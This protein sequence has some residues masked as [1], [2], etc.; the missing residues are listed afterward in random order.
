MSKFA[1]LLQFLLAL[2]GCSMGGTTWTSQVE[3]KGTTLHSKVRLEDGVAQ[4]HCLDSSSGQCHYTLF[5]EACGNQGDCQLAPLQRFSVLRG[6]SRQVAGL[7]GFKPCVA[8]D[9]AP[10]GADCQPVAAQPAAAVNRSAAPAAP[11]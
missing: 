6:E 7:A 10:M 1:A 5:P 11:N 2:S 8:I 4:F 3:D 9:A